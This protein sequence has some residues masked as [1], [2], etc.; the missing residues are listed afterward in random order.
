MLPAAL[1]TLR[2]I[3]EH[4]QHEACKIA[5]VRLVLEHVMGEHALGRTSSVKPEGYDDAIRV[6]ELRA[7]LDEIAK[8]QEAA[9]A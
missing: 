8:R 2:E 4:G 3:L 1:E 6:P 7:V 9:S 5:A